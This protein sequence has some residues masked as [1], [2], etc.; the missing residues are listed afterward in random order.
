[1]KAGPFRQSEMGV[2]QLEEH[3]EQLKGAATE[4]SQSEEH[5]EGTEED[6]SQK[7]SPPPPISRLAANPLDP[8]P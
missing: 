3:I 7:K 4:G 8:S 6:S 1:M 2:A 5:Q